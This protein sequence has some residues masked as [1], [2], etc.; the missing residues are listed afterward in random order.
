M[1]HNFF[2]SMVWLCGQGRTPPCVDM[3]FTDFLAKWNKKNTALPPQDNPG[4]IASG[5]PGRRPF[6][7]PTARPAKP[8]NTLHLF[9]K[10]CALA[11]GR[12][13]TV[14]AGMSAAGTC[15]RAQDPVSAATL[16]CRKTAGAPHFPAAYFL[17]CTPGDGGLC[18]PTQRPQIEIPGGAPLDGLEPQLLLGV[19]HR[20]ALEAPLGK[21][22]EGLVGGHLLLVGGQLLK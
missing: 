17:P 15:V 11:G 2:L 12:R 10:W 7:E 18:L 6:Q 21:Q 16:G 8:Y 22:G 3:S 9:H 19:L 1:N 4:G 20:L 5:A 14:P 13:A